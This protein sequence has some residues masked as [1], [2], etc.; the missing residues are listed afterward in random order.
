M[1][2]ELVHVNGKFDAEN[3]MRETGRILTEALLSIKEEEEV[4]PVLKTASAEI[5]VPLDNTVFE[6]YR[7]LGIL[8]TPAVDGTG[9]T[10]YAVISEI[11]ALCLGDFTFALIPGEIFPE[12][13]TGEYFSSARC[14]SPENTNPTALRDIAAS[15]GHDRLFILGLAN[16]ELGYIIPPNDFLVNETTPYFENIL[17][18]YGENHYEETNSTGV[19]TAQVIADALDELLGSLKK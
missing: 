16:D 8:D 11:G 9:A 4:S 6:Y 2:K 15:H 14:A 12:L 7:F 1:T 17:D 5:T 3:N 19:F 18:A 10:G 13:V